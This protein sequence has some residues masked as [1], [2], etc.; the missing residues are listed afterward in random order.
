[1]VERVHD[2][3]AARLGAQQLRGAIREHLVDGHVGRRAAASL[4]ERDRELIGEGAGGE[5][6]G[7]AHDRI[8]DR[9]LQHAELAVR[10][11]RG[12]LDLGERAQQLRPIAE[13]CRGRT[14][15]GSGAHG[16]RAVERRG[17]H[18]DRA[19]HVVFG[20]DLTHRDATRTVPVVQ[21]D[22]S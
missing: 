14:E 15:V 10:L 13:S 5:L 3:G 12:G 19:K 20:T 22:T 7:R 6:V 2:V 4:H 1:M 18:G 11:G 16:L 17:R 9:R 8:G 21:V